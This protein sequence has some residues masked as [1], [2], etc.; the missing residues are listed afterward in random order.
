MTELK[1]K[2]PMC[3]KNKA[4]SQFYRPPCY[5]KECNR[6]YRRKWMLKNYGS[7]SLRNTKEGDKLREYDKKY[8]KDKRA[9]GL[10]DKTE[11]SKRWRQKHPRASHAYACVN[12]EI[13]AGRIKRGVCKCG[14][15]NTYAHHDDYNDPYKISWKCP[16]CH[17]K[18][19]LGLWSTS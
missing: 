3:K 6:K 15:R 13:K 10:V 2:C 1:R 7:L 18:Y 17:K 19:H 5:C 14:K 4:I 9:M 16:S 8:Q 12:R 11:E